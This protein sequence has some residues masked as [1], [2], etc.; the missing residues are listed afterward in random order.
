MSPFMEIPQ[1]SY[2]KEAFGTSFDSATQN[3]WIACDY[4]NQKEPVVNIVSYKEYKV[5]LAAS[6]A[7]KELLNTKIFALLS[8]YFYFCTQQSS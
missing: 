7:S 3:G 6:K 8:L 4:F 5:R 2:E 1:C